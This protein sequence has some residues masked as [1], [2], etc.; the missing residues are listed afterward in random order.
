VAVE[1]DPVRISMPLPRLPSTT[2]SAF[3]MQARYPKKD[4]RIESRSTGSRYTK[5]RPPEWVAVP[6]GEERHD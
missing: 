6:P 4:V 2:G 3:S 5:V 1:G